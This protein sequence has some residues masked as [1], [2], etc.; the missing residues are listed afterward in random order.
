MAETGTP[1]AG[2]T[3][4]SLRAADGLAEEYGGNPENGRR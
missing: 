4:T 2:G 3:D 1:I